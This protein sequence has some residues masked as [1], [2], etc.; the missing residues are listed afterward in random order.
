MGIFALV[1]LVLAAIGIYGVLSYSVS[2]RAREIGIRMALGAKA[3]QVRRI[4]VGQ[5]VKLA[6]LGI[7]VGLAGALA[8]GRLLD[9]MVFEVSVA[10]PVVLA[11]VA[12]GLAAVA[13]LAS[14][15]PARRATRV[16]SIDALREE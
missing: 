14:Y 15:L 16:D 5:G 13:M 12:I 1:A 7:V 3:V 9:S 10:D 4:V 2:Q 6:A 8:L 11:S